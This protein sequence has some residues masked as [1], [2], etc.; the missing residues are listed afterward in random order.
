[1]ST[2]PGFALAFFGFLAP[3]VGALTIG[4][5]RNTRRGV[6]LA[7]GWSM[8]LFVL[9]VVFG[10]DGLFYLLGVQGVVCVCVCVGAALIMFSLGI[11]IRDISGILRGHGR[12]L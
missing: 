4:H 5:L 7:A 9:A 6:L 3:F 10:L 12:V 2:V 11:P 1:M 8:I